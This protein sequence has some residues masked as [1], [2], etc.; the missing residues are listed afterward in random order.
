MRVCLFDDFAGFIALKHSMNALVLFRAFALEN[1]RNRLKIL[2]R[3]TLVIF[4]FCFAK[5]TITSI[6][7]MC[8][9]VQDLRESKISPSLADGY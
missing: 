8:E 1:P 5:I 4:Y 2:P 7:L 9:F 3:G 6:V